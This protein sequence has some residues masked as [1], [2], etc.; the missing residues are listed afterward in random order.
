MSRPLLII[1]IGR[2]AV[3]ACVLADGKDDGMSFFETPLKGDIKAS[4]SVL[5]REM[6]GAGFAAPTRV[7]LGLPPDV[8]SLRVVEVPLNERQKALEVLPFEL[9]ERLIKGTGEFIFEA[10]T[11]GAGRTMAVALEK[12]LLKEYLDALG[13]MGLEPS[14][15]GCS[16][17]SKDRLLGELNSAKSHAA[18]LDSESIVIS[19]GTRPLL[20]KKVTGET[21]VRLALASIEGDGVEIKTFYCCGETSVAFVPPGREVH[22]VEQ[23]DERFTGL[24]A[25]VLQLRGG[26]GELINFRKGEFADTAAFERARRG[27]KTTVL[28]MFI[29]AVLWGGLVA[30]QSR[31][32]GGEAAYLKKNISL[33]YHQ[34]FPGE[35]NVQDPLYSLEIKLK[36]QSKDMGLLG[37]GIGVLDNIGLLAKAGGEAGIKLYQLSMRGTR[38]TAKG[39]AASVEKAMLFKAGLVRLKAFTRPSLTDVK[40]SLNGG[41]TFS[42]AIELNP[43]GV[44]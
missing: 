37:R 9:S 34:A 17:F 27:F 15:V 31:R 12:S 41:V 4:L 3:R 23:W 36:E 33:S 20:Y 24:K 30:L 40:T 18:F 42:I 16:L 5:M 11:L 38:V 22:I 26:F 14:H 28:L 8:L 1:D 10:L 32:I 29:V 2:D 43:E 35:K 39:R 19:D 7:F 21:D 44:L 13:E 6:G 25:L